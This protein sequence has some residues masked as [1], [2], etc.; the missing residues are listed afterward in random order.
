MCEQKSV[1]CDPTQNFMKLNF[2]TSIFERT[3]WQLDKMMKCTQVSPKSHPGG[4]KA[5]YLQ[6]TLTVHPDRKTSLSKLQ[7]F[8]VT[9]QPVSWSN[10]FM[11]P[12][13]KKIKVW[14]DIWEWKLNR[15]PLFV[16]D[17]MQAYPFFKGD[18]IMSIWWQID[19]LV[20]S[21]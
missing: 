7:L 1:N 15:L 13:P 12:S 16:A 18:S 8:A 11:M 17:L 4:R 9:N 10:P 20:C 2:A 5:P 21:N 14:K 3:R 6:P 19:F